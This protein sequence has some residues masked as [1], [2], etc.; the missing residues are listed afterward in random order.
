MARLFVGEL[1]ILWRRMSRGVSYYQKYDCFSK[2]Y[3]S[4]QHTKILLQWDHNGRDGVSKHQLHHCLLSLLFRRKSKKISKLRVTGLC[5]EN[6]P[7]TDEFPAQ[8]ASNTENISIKW[9]HHAKTKHYWSYVRKPPIIS[10]L[11]LQRTSNSGS[12][13]MSFCHDAGIVLT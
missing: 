9:R 1:P 10:G 13:L 8:R 3:S 7:M 2:A 5:A 4:W 6:S 11:S 12:V